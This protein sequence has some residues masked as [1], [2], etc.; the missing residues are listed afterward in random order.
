MVAGTQRQV[1]SEYPETVLREAVLNALSHRD[2]GLTGATV[3]ITVW[4]D[5]IEIRSPGSLPGHITVENMRDDHYSRNRRMM[6]TLKLVGLVEEYGEGVD[7]MFT[8]MEA[9]LME[10]PLF[11]ATPSSVSVVI[12]NRFLVDVED[13]VWLALASPNTVQLGSS[14]G[15]F[16][17]AER[18]GPVGVAGSFDVPFWHLAFDQS[19]V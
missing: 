6:R 4:D 3:D 15:G 7:R 1:L 14:D 17:W 11:T 13:Q 16:G 12:R 10:P 2:Y 8:E 19:R 18:L 9:R 5:R